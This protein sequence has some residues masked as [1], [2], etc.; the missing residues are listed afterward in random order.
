MTHT[1][2]GWRERLRAWI[3]KQHGTAGWQ[4]KLENLM[5][6]EIETARREERK[7]IAPWID[8]NV[9]VSSKAIYLYMTTGKKPGA[10]DAPSDSGDRGRCIVLLKAVP[11]WIPRLSEIEEMHLQVLVNG[12]RIEEH[13]N[14]QIPLIRASLQSH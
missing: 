4:V 14:E 3:K 6:A 9:G 13:W 7:K 8:G 5:E 2:E 12:T 10:V 11:E 1:Q